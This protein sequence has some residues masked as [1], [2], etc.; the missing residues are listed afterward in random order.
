MA[1]IAGY[2][3]WWPGRFATAE[4][5]NHIILKLGTCQAAHYALRVLH[6]LENPT[7]H[8]GDIW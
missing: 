2:L 4:K 3:T 5:L 8:Y 6:R 7:S 1:R